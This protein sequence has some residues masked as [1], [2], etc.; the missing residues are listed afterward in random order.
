[1]VIIYLSPQTLGRR[2]FFALKS[3]EW[4]SRRHLF[5][6][7]FGG[8]SG[9][10]C[11]FHFPSFFRKLRKLVSVALTSPPFTH[12]SYGEILGFNRGTL[13]SAAWTFLTTLLLRAWWRD[14]PYPR[15]P[16][17]ISGSVNFWK[18]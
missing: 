5:D 2:S 13:S 11:P 16:I 12:T 14:Y 1:M 18:N 9:E 3:Y 6:V 7:Q 15:A 17:I 8:C 10:D 4:P